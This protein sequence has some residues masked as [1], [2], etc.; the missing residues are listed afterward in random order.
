MTHHYNIAFE[1]D[2][3]K[4]KHDAFQDFF[5]NIMERRY[6]GDFVRVRPWGAS[7]DE[8]NDGYLASK[9]MLFQVYAPNDM[10]AAIA[11]AKI[12]NDYDGAKKYWTKYF[13]TWVFTHNAWDGLSPHITKKLQEL[14]DLRPPNVT[15]WGME[16]LRKEALDLDLQSLVTLFGP[17]PSQKDMNNLRFDDIE[18]VLAHVEASPPSLEID[19]RAVPSSKLD[20]NNL[21]SSVK[22]LLNLGMQKANRVSEYF[23]QQRIDLGYGNKLSEAFKLQYKKLHDNQLSADAIFHELYRFTGGENV[24]SPSET[25][26]VYAILAY[27]FETCDIFER[28]KQ[29]K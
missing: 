15:W 14:H 2:F 17:A 22:A 4:A 5:S 3:M 10:K 13:D 23:E 21:S 19:L 8:K 18:R 16:E 9:R 12:Q 27:F 1:R 11:I 28:P 25:V 6:P 20:E 29:A 24:N 7:G 26:A